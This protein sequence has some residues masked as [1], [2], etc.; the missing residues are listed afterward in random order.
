MEFQ[1]ERQRRSAPSEEK[2]DRPG[3]CI[4]EKS[5]NSNHREETR[6]KRSHNL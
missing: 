5:V 1:K 6:K 3:E 2:G 4:Q